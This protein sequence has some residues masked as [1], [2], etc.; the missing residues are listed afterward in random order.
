MG[1]APGQVAEVDI[2]VGVEVSRVGVN[3]IA[4][5]VAG[6]GVRLAKI[7]ARVADGRGELMITAFVVGVLAGMFAAMLSGESAC[8]ARITIADS[9]LTPVRKKSGAYCL[10]DV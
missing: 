7:G 9:I 3:N 10:L 2:S 4:V 5:C 8:D 6:I 1:G